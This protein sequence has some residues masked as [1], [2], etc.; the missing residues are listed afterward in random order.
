MQNDFT[1]KLISVL[2]HEVKCVNTHYN[3][4]LDLIG[5]LYEIRYSNFSSFRQGKE[6]VKG[7]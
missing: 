3:F 5:T 1:L 4:Q 7:Q 6:Q 2:N